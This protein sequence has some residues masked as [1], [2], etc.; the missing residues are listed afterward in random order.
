MAAKVRC[1]VCRHN[2]L[3][4]EGKFGICGVRQNQKGKIVLTVYGKASSIAVDP[5]EKKPLYHVLPGSPIL[6]IGSLGCNFRCSFCQ[7]WEISQAMREPD[8]AGA[9]RL[10]DAEPETLIEQCVK[11][12]IPAIAFTYNEPAILL[13]WAID[14]FTL[15]KKHNITTVFVSNGY[16]SDESILKLRGLLDA[17]NIDLKAFTPGFYA[18]ECGAKFENVLKTIE[19]TKKAGIWLEL[20]TLLI[21]GLND[22]DEELKKAAAWIAQ[23]DTEIPWHITAFHPDY[24]LTHIGP[25]PARTLENAYEIAK[26]AGLDYVYVGNIRNPHENTVCPE[27]GAVL[28]ERSGFAVLANNLKAGKCPTCNHRIPGIWSST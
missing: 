14:T 5:M 9:V 26:K 21:P 4:P 6:S 8:L 1:G 28:I 10:A 17:V 11:R 27:C 24:K 2:C 22:S 3:I 15:A 20:T 13:E 16:A 18:K 12:K 23:L 25:T 7:N 19:A